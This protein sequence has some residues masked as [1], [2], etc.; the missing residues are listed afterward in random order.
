MQIKSAKDLIEYQ[1]AYELAEIFAVSKAF[2]GEEDGCQ[3]SEVKNRLDETQTTV[4]GEQDKFRKRVAGLY[5]G[6]RPRDAGL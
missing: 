5:Q 1:K 4:N 2:R 3:V 6:L